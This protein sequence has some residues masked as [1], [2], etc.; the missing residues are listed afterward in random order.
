MFETQT[1]IEKIQG[2]AQHVF[3][4]FYDGL[5]PSC[6]EDVDPRSCRDRSVPS[7]RY[8][9]KKYHI[10]HCAHFFSIRL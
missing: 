4:W 5:L 9:W 2:E 3:A 10:C 8:K 7:V 6:L 1:P